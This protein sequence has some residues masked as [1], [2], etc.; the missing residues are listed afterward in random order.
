LNP[1]DATDRKM[2]DDFFLWQGEVGGKK[3]NAGKIFK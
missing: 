2:V 3:F 1:D